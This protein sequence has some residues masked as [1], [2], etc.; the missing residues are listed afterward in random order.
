M[1]CPNCL[2][3]VQSVV[4][5]ASGDV[6]QNYLECDNCGNFWLSELSAESLIPMSCPNCTQATGV[7]VALAIGDRLPR[8]LC[9]RCGEAL[10]RGRM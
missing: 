8:V 4:T 10:T 5:I 6:S 1:Q 7:V 9:T 3:S 2:C